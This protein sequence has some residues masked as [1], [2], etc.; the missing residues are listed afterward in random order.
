M[1]GCWEARGVEVD[2]GGIGETSRDTQRRPAWPSRREIVGS[3]I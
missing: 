3:A 1:G 2:A